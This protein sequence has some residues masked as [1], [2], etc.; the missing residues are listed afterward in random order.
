MHS[1]YTLSLLLLLLTAPLA[2][3]KADRPFN[4]QAPGF[5][6]PD[7]HHRGPSPGTGYAPP[8]GPPAP[9]HHGSFQQPLPPQQQPAT[10]S[11]QLINTTGNFEGM[12][13]AIQHRDNNTILCV[14]L[15][16]GY[17]FKVISSK[18]PIK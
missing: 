12:Q 17:Q 3:S 1:T 7:A 11:T 8:T 18:L 9:Q 15:H 16:P 5:P 10:G 4:M 6:N 14:T 2:S 13:F